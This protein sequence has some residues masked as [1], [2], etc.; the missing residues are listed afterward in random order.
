MGTWNA[1]CGITQMPIVDGTPVVFFP[2]VVHQQDF[3]A[4]DTLAGIGSVSNNLIAQPLSLPIHGTYCGYGALQ[5]VSGDR[6]LEYLREF[7]ARLVKNGRLLK[8]HNAHPVPVSELSTNF[9][10]DL[11]AGDFLLRVHN[12]RKSW[13]MELKKLVAK[14]DNKAGLSHYADQLK[15]DPATLPDTLDLALSAMLVPQTLY[16]Q[17]CASAGAAPGHETYDEDS[18][19]VVCFQGNRQA[20]LSQY[21]NISDAERAELHAEFAE[22]D[23]RNEVDPGLASAMQMLK[24]VYPLKFA[25]RAQE[26]QKEVFFITACTDSALRA[27]IADNDIAARALWVSMMLFVGVLAT[28][29]KQWSPQ[30]GAGS[31]ATAKDAAGFYQVTIDYMRQQLSECSAE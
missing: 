17:L 7:L 27:C 9:M 19:E 20:Q 4:R 23:A 18:Q 2:L 8:L 11:C 22:Y 21:C 3:L 30:T 12:S 31:S 29:R 24:Q 13:L 16:E 14:S 1:T 25:K 6:G 26:V 10:Q 15:V 5:A 28:M